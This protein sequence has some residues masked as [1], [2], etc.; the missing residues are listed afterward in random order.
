MVPRTSG[1]VPNLNFDLIM[2]IR[3]VEAVKRKEKKKQYIE[4]R[5]QAVKSWV[6]AQGRAAERAPFVGR[7][8]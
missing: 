8:F 4:I 3:I 2:W 1:T 6:D 7:A 5:S